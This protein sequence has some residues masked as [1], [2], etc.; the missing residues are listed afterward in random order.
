MLENAV[1]IMCLFAIYTGTV[2]ESR[3]SWD[4]YLFFSNVKFEPKLEEVVTPGVKTKQF[5]ETLFWSFCS[6][7]M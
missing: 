6:M 1:S 4:F 5:F 2:L 3:G 7:V